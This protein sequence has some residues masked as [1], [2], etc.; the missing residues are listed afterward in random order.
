ME[1][2]FLPTT[3][4]LGMAMWLALVNKIS[5]N[6]RCHFQSK[7][8][9]VDVLFVIHFPLVTVTGDISDG[10]GLCHTRFLLYIHVQYN[11]QLQDLKN[12]QEINVYKY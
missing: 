7:F 8:L 1:G 9:R 11:F 5:E 12:E 6:D 3:L 10:G 2:L 4:K